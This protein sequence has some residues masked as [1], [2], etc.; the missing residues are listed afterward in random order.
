MGLF[1]PLS[2]AVKRRFDKMENTT[3]DCI[4]TGSFLAYWSLS[5][6]LRP[7]SSCSHRAVASALAITAEKAEHL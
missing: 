1:R 5:A 6:Y 7:T 3:Y 4:I 2:V